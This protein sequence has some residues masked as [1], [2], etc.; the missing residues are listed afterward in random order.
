MWRLAKMCVYQH[1]C[2]KQVLWYNLCYDLVSCCTQGNFDD[3]TK[4]WWHHNSTEHIATGP[5]DS[6]FNAWYWWEMAQVGIDLRW[7]QFWKS[8][9]MGHAAGCSWSFTLK[10]WRYSMCSLPY[11]WNIEPFLIKQLDSY[12]MIRG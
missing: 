10:W 11:K 8:N 12:C 5:S 7:R 4:T 1:P 9:N 3:C 6:L 2:L